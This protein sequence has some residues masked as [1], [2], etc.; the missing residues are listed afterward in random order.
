[1]KP[2]SPRDGVLRGGTALLVRVCL[3]I[4]AAIS[5]YLL[6]LS[7]G[8]GN[9]V[10]CA[11]GSSCDEVLQSRWAYVFGLPVSGLALIV[12]LAL[13]LTTFACTPKSSVAQRRGA[14]EIIV[15]CAVLVL[16]AAVWFTALQAFVLNKFC[17]WC[18][19]AHAAGS[20]AALVLLTKMPIG[21]KRD[22]KSPALTA[23]VAVLLSLVALVAVG[24]LGA[25]QALAPRRTFTVANIPPETASVTS[26][27][28]SP[29]PPATQTVAAPAPTPTVAARP[30][31]PNV[32]PV[33][34]GRFVLN[35]AEVPVWG[36]PNAPVKLLSMHDYTCHHCRD[37]HSRVVEVHHALSNDVAIVS[38]PMPLDH[39]CNRL[40]RRTPP[41]HVNACTYARLGLAVWRAKP[42][43]IEPFDDW[44]FAFEKPPTLE[45]VTNKAI[46]MV[47]ADAFARASQDPLIDKLIGTAIEIYATSANQYGQPR[48]PQFI[49]GTNAASGMMTAEQLR[50][51]VQP[52]VA[53]R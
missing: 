12:D 31:T 40:M 27:T 2:S 7:L 53:G 42:A 16:A 46:E 38:L 13:L 51:L 3:L 25:A 47:G 48:M 23:R 1:M 15:P 18:L 4:A 41:A 9:A 19:G 52:Y 21:Q 26:N 24:A 49:I 5:G 32:L 22:A 11:P 50:A 39:T 33:F 8:G 10:G 17:P 35:L 30:Q 14:W 45:A 28:P 34:N 43:A 29:A 6:S 37:M 36:N 44:F 20:I